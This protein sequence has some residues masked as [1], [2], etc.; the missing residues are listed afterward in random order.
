MYNGEIQSFDWSTADIVKHGA[1][2]STTITKKTTHLVVTDEDYRKNSS[3]KVLIAKDK[4]DVSIVTWDWVQDSI[5]AKCRKNELD[6]VLSE[7]PGD[8][9]DNVD[10]NDANINPGKHKIDNTSES[11]VVIPSRKKRRAA[12]HVIEEKKMVK[13]IKKG[14]APVDEL[15]QMKDSYHVFSNTQA[16]WD[17]L[18]NQ[19]N[20]GTNNNKFFIIQ[21]LESDSGGSYYVY[22]RWGR[23]GYDGQQA[24]SGPWSSL[25]MAKYEFEKKFRDK[26]KNKWMDICQDKSSFKAVKGK[27]TLL[28]RDYGDDEVD[29]LTKNNAVVPPPPIPESKLHPKIQNIIKLIFDVSLWNDTMV[30]LNYDASKLPL[31]KLSK[32]TITRGYEIL[33]N[34][35]SVLTKNDVGDLVELSND[36]YTVIPHNFGFNKPPIINNIAILKTKMAMVEALGEIE[37]A[38]SLIKNADISKNP[39]D[40]NYDLLGLE[41]MVPLD[42]DSEEFKLIHNYVKNTQGSTHHIKLE[43]LDVFDIERQGERERYK[44]YS[45]LHNRMLLWH[46]SRRTNYV[47]ILSQGLRIAPPH[48]P[49]SGYMFGKGVYFAD[50][51][52][53][54]ANYCRSHDN[55]GFLLLCEVACGDMLELVNSDYNAD[56]KVKKQGKHCTKGLG[57][58]VPDPKGAVYLENGTM[59]PCGKGLSSLDTDKCLY[60]NEYIVYDVSQIFQKYLLRV[61][62]DN[63]GF[64]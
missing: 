52:S 11:D 40:A 63:Q 48:V 32:N 61:K 21:L 57:Q 27:Y 22:S 51:V 18:L 53:K 62:F 31:G 19:T 44:P 25:D 56:E 47:G 34:I 16:T 24:M 7:L 35:E 64:Y 41:R 59:V 42:H 8:D 36:F 15:F 20:A 1:T 4:N 2:V 43:I 38:S 30:E 23:V 50:C 26:T 58:I 49:V 13:I 3:S 55:I 60:Y 9:V 29:I 10:T 33:K 6:Y 39:L 45:K 17:C 12:K 5:N 14:K 46:G 54:S 28:E 37:I